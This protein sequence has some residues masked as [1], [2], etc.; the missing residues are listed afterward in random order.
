M[1][2]LA[3]LPRQG[4]GPGPADP[5]LLPPVGLKKYR[6]YELILTAYNII[7]ESP[8]SAPVEVFVG[9]AG[10]LQAPCPPGGLAWHSPGRAVR[11]R[12][13]AWGCC[14][15]GSFQVSAGKDGSAKG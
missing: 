1:W 4:V 13:E 9:E 10:K 7:G 12:L 2:P 14:A 11:L 8:A 5:C 15:T 3:V 6:R